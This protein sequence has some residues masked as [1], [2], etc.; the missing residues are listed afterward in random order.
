MIRFLLKLVALVLIM[1]LIYGFWLIYQER[2]PE[3]RL[4]VRER[5]V[6]ILREGGRLVVEAF[7]RAFDRLISLAREK[8]PA[9]SE[10]VE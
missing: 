9:S 6:W 7:R 1:A 8:A 2:N 3:E 5:F 4:E 10:Q